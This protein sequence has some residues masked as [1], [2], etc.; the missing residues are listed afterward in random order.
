MAGRDPRFIWID[1]TREQAR[2]LLEA[3]AGNDPPGFAEEF[4]YSVRELYAE[5][6][7]EVLQ[8]FGIYVPEDAIPEEVGTP[9]EDEARAIL[10]DLESADAAFPSYAPFRP[11]WCGNPPSYSL[12]FAYIF[13]VV[14]E[15]AADR[16]STAD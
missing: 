2:E 13:E 9:T 5:R 4:G 15:R 1:S 8:Y 10:E 7:R 3:L 6:T 14:A 12:T 16:P 11:P